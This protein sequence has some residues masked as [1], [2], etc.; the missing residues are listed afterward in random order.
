[1]E[2][3]H[4]DKHVSPYRSSVKRQMPDIGMECD[5]IVFI[6]KESMFADIVE[7]YIY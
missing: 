7:P 5:I 1:M 6:F 4:K 3:S 2:T